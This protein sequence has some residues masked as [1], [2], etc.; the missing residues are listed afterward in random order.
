MNKKDINDDRDAGNI[1]DAKVNEVESDGIEV[2]SRYSHDYVR[3]DMEDEHT[4]RK[5]K[6]GKDKVL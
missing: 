4:Q 5:E 2:D 3:E 6:A 1:K